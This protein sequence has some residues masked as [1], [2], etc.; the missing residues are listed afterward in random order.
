VLLPARLEASKAIPIVTDDGVLVDQE[1]VELGD[2][3]AVV[4]TVYAAPVQVEIFT[5][6]YIVAAASLGAHV[7]GAD[8]V[9]LDGSRLPVV[10]GRHG[11]AA[12]NDEKV[13][14]GCQVSL[15]SYSGEGGAAVLLGLVAGALAA[16][17]PDD[18][19][20]FRVKRVQEDSH[21]R[22]DPGAEIDLVVVDDRSSAGRP[23]AHQAVVAEESSLAGAA[24]EFPRQ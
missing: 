11:T 13:F 22:P 10:D 15:R 7:A 16:V 8:V 1:G 2:E 9:V 18:P 19:A 5:E 4:E 24:A 12:G 17:G 23:G 3:L 14:V 6:D 21:E 20:G